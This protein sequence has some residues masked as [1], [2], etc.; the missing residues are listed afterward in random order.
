MDKFLIAA[1]VLECLRLRGLHANETLIHNNAIPF[2]RRS[3]IGCQ[4]HGRVVTLGS[5]SKLPILETHFP[6]RGDQNE[7]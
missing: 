7:A 6:P 5:G 1:T 4:K 2:L 3:V